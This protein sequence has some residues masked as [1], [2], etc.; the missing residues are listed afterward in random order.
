M[1]KQWG[2]VR[3]AINAIKNPSVAREDA[4]AIGDADVAFDG[5]D[6]YVAEETSDADD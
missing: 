2:R 4:S 3:E 6:S 1:K 5:R